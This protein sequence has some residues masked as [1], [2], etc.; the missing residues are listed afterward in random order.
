MG[1]IRILKDHLVVNKE[2]GT[3]SV[4]TRLRHKEQVW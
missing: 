4:R 1:Y 3:E 2:W